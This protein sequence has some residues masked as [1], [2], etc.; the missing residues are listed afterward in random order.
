MLKLPDAYMNFLAARLRLM[1]HILHTI[2]QNIHQYTAQLIRIR[3]NHYGAVIRMYV[4]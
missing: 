3:C 1:P 4:C 2:F